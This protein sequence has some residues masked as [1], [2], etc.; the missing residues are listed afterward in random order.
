MF[1]MVSTP[2]HK[3]L[4]TKIISINDAKVVNWGKKETLNERT[5]YQLIHPEVVETCQLSLGVTC[6]KPGSV[7][8]TYPPHTHERRMECYLYFD[9]DHESE[10]YHFMGQ[11]E[12]VRNIIMRD[13]DCVVNPPWSVHYGVGTKSYSF[14]WAMAGENKDWTDMDFIETK[15]LI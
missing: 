5:I 3:V 8:N 15:D 6:L 4:P 14:V 1:Y 10:V 9:L 2:A 12:D 13:K 11:K 7:W